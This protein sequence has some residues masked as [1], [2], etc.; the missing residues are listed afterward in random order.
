MASGNGTVGGN[1]AAG[2]EAAAAVEAGGLEETAFSRG[3]AWEG[4]SNED[5]VR[6]GRAAG[7]EGL[8]FVFIC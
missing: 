7:P 3:K 6:K 2:E 1:T 5:D 4:E 8:L